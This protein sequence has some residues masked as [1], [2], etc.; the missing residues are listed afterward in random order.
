VKKLLNFLILGFVLALFINASCTEPDPPIPTGD[1]TFSCSIN[2][3][4]FLPKGTGGGWSSLPTGDGLYFN[5]YNSNL[6]YSVS[7]SNSKFRVYLGIYNWKVGTFT[8]TDSDGA[9]HPGDRGE[10]NHAI[11]LKNGVKYLSKQGS[12]SVVFTVGTDAD[13]KGTFEFDV[14]NENNSDDILH[15]TNGQFD[16]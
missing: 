1:H 3:E 14:Y 5:E 12:G 7:A 10:I 8:L 6:S 15:I 11:V 2:G 9:F 13:S 4:L 16:D